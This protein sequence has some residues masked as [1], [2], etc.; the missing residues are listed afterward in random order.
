MRRDP[1]DSS[2]STIATISGSDDAEGNDDTMKI[3]GGRRCNKKFRARLRRYL[4]SIGSEKINGSPCDILLLDQQGRCNYQTKDGKFDV[5]IAQDAKSLSISTCV[6][7][8]NSEV[9]SLSV[10]KRALELNHSA[11]GD[12]HGFS[13]GIDPG[14]PDGSKMMPMTLGVT[15]SMTRMN[16]SDVMVTLNNFIE[17]AN[18]IRSKLEEAD[19]G[20]LGMAPTPFFRLRAPLISN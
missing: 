19:D 10:M 11:R 17:I 12:R 3:V 20:R 9:A 4:S 16:R 8:C 14:L 2:I 7:S 15:R 1:S 6:Y 18:N 5:H 13:L